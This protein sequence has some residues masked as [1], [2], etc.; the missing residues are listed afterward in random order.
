MRFL[1][2]LF[3]ILLSHHLC[4]QVGHYY[5]SHYASE[6]QGSTL[7]FDMTQDPAGLMYFATRTGLKQFDGRNWRAI[8]AK[9][10]T[11][12]LTLGG[13]GRVFAAGEGMIG[14]V[15]IAE[16]YSL[17]VKPIHSEPSI[18]FFESIAV[19]DDVYFV[20]E[21]GIVN[22]NVVSAKI[23]RL[24]LPAGEE[25]FANL[26]EVLGV[27]FVSTFDGS[28]YKVEGSTLTES[29]FALNS[30][31]AFTVGFNN[32]Y[33]IV[34]ENQ[35]C[36]LMKEGFI[37]KPVLFNDQPYLA[38]GV[39]VSGAWVT[40]N[41]LA[42]GTLN[43]GVVFVNPSTGKT[44]EIINYYS[45]LPDN[46]VFCLKR[47]A[48]GNVW[49]GHEYGYS[50]ISPNLP[51]RSFNHYE[52]LEGNILCSKTFANT[53][54]VGTSVG[55]FIL[56][57]QDQYT[58][59]VYY[60][61]KKVTTK[62]ANPKAVPVVEQKQESKKKGFLR[63]RKNKEAAVT[64][65]PTEEK[66]AEAKAETVVTRIRQTRKV[67]MG[68]TYTFKRVSGIDS[69]VERLIIDNG[70]LYAA[71]LAGLFEVQ[72]A[73]ALSIVQEPV[74]V[75]SSTL[76]HGIVGETFQSRVFAWKDNVQTTLI[77][78]LHDD[79]SSVIEDSE[80]TLWIS[81]TKNI[82]QFIDGK[83]VGTYAYSN[84]RLDRTEG[85]NLK[86][87]AFFVNSNGFYTVEGGAVRVIDSLGK[88]SQFF[89]SGNNLWYRKNETWH[90][91]GSFQEHQNL[92]YLNVFTDLRFIE[93]E[94]ETE[95]LWIVTKTN[96]LFRFHSNQQ[97][98]KAAVYPLFVRSVRNQQQFF[99]PGQFFFRLGQHEGE[100][101][102]EAVQAAF[103]S[104]QGAQ[105]RYLLVGL[106]S[107]GWSDWSSN[108]QINFP[109]LPLGN[110]V[111][112]LQ[113]RDGLGNVNELKPIQLKIEPPFWRTPW[114][115]AMEFAIFSVLV[116]LSIRLQAMNNRYRIIAQVLA[117]LT[118]VLL[119]TL[120]QA[121][122]STYLV[123]TSP[124]IDFG[125]QVGVAFLVLPVE[126]FLRKVM[127]S[128]GEKNKLYQ[129]INPS[130]KKPTDSF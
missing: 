82:Y 55:L 98:A 91:L 65:A 123:T 117:M 15:T 76:R 71:G 89:A 6:Q 10:I 64:P 38:S 79:V 130:L 62:S 23:G 9:G 16:N 61:D 124:I 41:L 121:A 102:I 108:N 25:G 51:F 60:I 80:G 2:V 12:T 114:F 3:G 63:F 112:K 66:P 105:Y 31:V 110:Y 93:T 125:I 29:S 20:S 1:G 27:A 111:L 24:K 119:I 84:P 129:I 109:F 106:E 97:V 8:E 42:L 95:A 96:E 75:V 37:L 18:D 88:P 101:A 107:E 50:C 32:Q 81:G 74:E 70:A 36:F 44:E 85:M 58:D 59:E 11:L 99:E 126:I 33:F 28:I 35:Q 4:A 68:S 56:E 48:E 39:I 127:F 14:Y 116:V 87:K 47:D 122:F 113:T 90:C 7:S 67:L 30:P 78:D 5:I 46:E 45:G 120:I 52:G 57:K 17:Q 54:Y 34:T 100:I 26:F 69:K 73:K 13:D 92:E 86:G 77:E 43:G 19:K 118:I 21:E 22:Y 128:V 115:Y 40:S 103:G 104:Q 72:K 94:E 49:V 83:P 53:V